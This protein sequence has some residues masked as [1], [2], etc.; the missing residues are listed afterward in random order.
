MHVMLRDWVP[1]SAFVLVFLVFE[2]CSAWTARGCVDLDSSTFDKVV[3]KFRYTLVKFDTA[4]PYG[5][6]HEAFTS[7]A[8][9]AGSNDELLF[10]LVGIKDYGEKDNTD[11]ETRFSIPKEYPV[12]KLFSHNI[13]KP[14]DFPTSEEISADSLRLFLKR[15]TDLYIGLPGCIQRLDDFVHTFLHSSDNV[16]KQSMIDQ[17]ETL[18]KALDETD[19]FKTSY[20]TYAA[21]MRKTLHSNKPPSV[22]VQDEM[23]RIGKIL[24]SK[25]SDTKRNDLKLRTNIMQSFLSESTTITSAHSSEL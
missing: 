21:L 20:K 25:L 23:D 4:F 6:K 2:E 15:N 10:A 24:Q 17:I 11:L 19:Q 14:I 1:L 8:Q 13:D 16:E 12:V 22:V 5:D 3:K 18:G 9:Q 7:L